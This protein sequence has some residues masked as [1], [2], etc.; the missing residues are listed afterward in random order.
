MALTQA[1][2][3]QQ[4]AKKAIARTAA[5][6]INSIA[7]PGSSD[8]A[9]NQADKGGAFDITKTP[10]K[11]QTLSDS[12]YANAVNSTIGTNDAS[13]NFTPTPTTSD[14]GSYDPLTK[15]GLNRQAVQAVD[16]QQEQLNKTRE[17]LGFTADEA[18]VSALQKQM[19]GTIEQARVVYKRQQDAIAERKAEQEKAMAD[20]ISSDRFAADTKK[21]EAA[22]ESI[23]ANFSS[24]RNDPQSQ[25]NMDLI[26]QRHADIQAG[27]DTAAN[28]LALAQR[29]RED[30]LANL[31]QA[32]INGN[33]QMVEEY[34]NQIARAANDILTKQKD[35]ADQQEKANK[36][37][38]DLSQQHATNTKAAFDIIKDL[39]PNSLEGLD[40]ASIAEMYNVPTT[41]ALTLQQLDKNKED[42]P[43]YQKKV[44]DAMYAGMSEDQK[45]F[46]YY[47]TLLKTDPSAALKFGQAAKILETTSAKDLWDKQDKD[48]QYALDYYDVKGSWPVGF[49]QGVNNADGSITIN[50]PV[51]SKGGQCGAW[52]NQKLDLPHF[53]G[54]SY[55]QKATKINSQT[56]VVGG[57]FISKNG[58]NLAD[59]T[60]T[61]HVGIVTKVYA[62]GS[63]DITDSNRHGNE[64]VDT[65]HVTNASEAGITGFFD[66]SKPA[67]GYSPTM[68]ASASSTSENTPPTTQSNS[69][70]EGALSNATDELYAQQVASGDLKLADLKA[71]IPEGGGAKFEKRA[72]S[73]RM[74]AIQERVAQIKQKTLDAKTIDD[75]TPEDQVLVKGLLDYSGDL[76]KLTSIRQDAAQRQKLFVIAKT[77][78]P[79]WSE[80]GFALRKQF[81]KDWQSGGDYQTNRDSLNTAVSHL[82]SLAEKGMDLHNSNSRIGNAVIN[83]VGKYGFDDPRVNNF[84]TE[85]NAVG[86]ELAKVFQGKGT[87]GQ[88]EKEAWQGHLSSNMGPNELK[89]SVNTAVELMIGR[90]ETLKNTYEQSMGQKLQKP[91]MSMDGIAKLVGLYQSGFLSASN[92]MK[93][94]KL[95]GGTISEA[96]KPKPSS[97]YSLPENK[98]TTPS[99]VD[100]NKL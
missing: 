97:A 79:T 61:G 6:T 10:K 27:V 72:A 74:A 54:D 98:P 40:V 60:N 56:P 14:A 71:A 41:T 1:Q 87:T 34:S 5:P 64:L 20:K 32:Q 66:P 15:S 85:Q 81:L 21:S 37:A 57:A 77:I 23:T 96:G 47:Q 100:I 67:P 78:D 92:L 43:D 99:K 52:V 75:L 36:A 49:D 39:P 29:G 73:Q 58:L 9:F 46:L 24:G 88:N 35:L 48:R 69:I 63:F 70:D 51:G 38:L 45:N 25:G 31:K 8:I 33:D 17:E 59:G 50:D 89:G 95:N 44:K 91:M 28:A 65:G 22:K 84:Q 7:T 3:N 12:A 93:V 16:Q 42:S 83:A 26:K 76:D 94:V 11:P 80:A 68:H 2:I 18:P 13:G 19:G 86:D 4:N 82:T 53:F 62:D 55:A 30:S 90:M